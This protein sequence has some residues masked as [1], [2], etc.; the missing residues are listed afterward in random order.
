M[1]QKIDGA[2]LLVE[3]FP[4]FSGLEISIITYEPRSATPAPSPPTKAEEP[5]DAL[6][7]KSTLVPSRLQRKTYTPLEEKLHLGYL[8]WTPS[9]RV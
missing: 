7:E 8:L 2:R 3:R 9:K 4:R 6:I 5:D 1:A